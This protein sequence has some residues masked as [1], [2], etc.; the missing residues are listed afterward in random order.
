MRKINKAP[1]DHC[2]ATHR[3][4]L[5]AG[6]GDICR[7]F[8]FPLTSSLPS[9]QVHSESLP[10]LHTGHS[11]IPRSRSGL[12]SHSQAH[13]GLAAWGTLSLSLCPVWGCRDWASPGFPRPARGFTSVVAR[14]Y[15]DHP[16]ERGKLNENRT[17]RSHE[18]TLVGTALVGPSPSMHPEW[19]PSWR[20]S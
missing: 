10:T 11:G 1:T 17:N 14:P 7:A 19:M 9:W 12:A 15:V 20:T 13:W 8:L 4:P 5:N 6:S 16:T 18:T 3:T 2:L